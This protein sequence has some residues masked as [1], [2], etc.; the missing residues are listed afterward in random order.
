LTYPV[1]ALTTRGLEAVSAQEM[2][3]LPGITVDQ[4]AY[5]RV[6]AR[7]TPSLLPLLALRT[8]DDLFLDVGRWPG[9]SH[10]RDGLAEIRLL[11]ERLNLNQAI[12]ALRTLRSLPPQPIFSVTASFVGRRNYT[13]DEIKN[14]V[15]QAVTAQHHW[16][17]TADDRQAY[18]NLRLFIEH[19]TAFIGLRLSHHPLHERAYKQIQRIGSLKPPIAAALLH[20]V[21]LSPA[22]LLLDPCCG[23]GTILIEAAQM[24]A[25]PHGGDSSL[26]AVTA[27][28]T[29]AHAAGLS[30]DIQH[31]DARALPLSSAAIDRIITNLPWGRQIT[32]DDELPAFYRAVCAEMERVIAP[33]GRIAVLT[34]TPNLLQFSNMRL[35]QQ[36]E[37]SLFGQNPTISVFLNK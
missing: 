35:D 28:Q 23:A 25:I 29:N 12:A 14:T 21:K 34:T 22:H 26:E 32:L 33:N 2:A 36:L 31:W 37:I 16:H 15:A 30:L 4:I 9:L 8:V 5:R 18:V 19:E 20:L 11:S 24:G 1:F 13:S 17:Y 7:C 27:A 3:A 6:T 10:R